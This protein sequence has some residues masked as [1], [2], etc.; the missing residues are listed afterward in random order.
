MGMAGVTTD[1]FLFGLTCISGLIAFIGWQAVDKLTRIDRD[2][3]S[4][5][6]Q[7]GERIARIE[8]ALQSMDRRR[9]GFG[10]DPSRVKTS[11]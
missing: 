2:V 9:Y 6:R 11:E 5:A 4:I 10:G 1:L 7:Y 3:Q 8:S